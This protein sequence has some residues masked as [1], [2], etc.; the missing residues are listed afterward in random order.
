MWV[1]TH[2]WYRCAINGSTILNASRPMRSSAI[3]HIFTRLSDII[4]VI[5]IIIVCLAILG[6]DHDY[7]P[8]YIPGERL[9]YSTH[10]SSFWTIFLILTQQTQPC[11]HQITCFKSRFSFLAVNLS[12]YDLNDTDVND[13]LQENRRL[14]VHCT[15]KTKKETAVKK[16]AHHRKRKWLDGRLH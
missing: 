16:R 11:R 1:E 5:G 12:I 8:C 6:A 15:W 3:T 9:P 4:S 13:T 2:K 10:Y 14:R 7:T